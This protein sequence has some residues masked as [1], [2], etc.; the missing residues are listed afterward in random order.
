MRQAEQ[1]NRQRQQVAVEEVF[2]GVSAPMFR[3]QPVGEEAQ[4]GG[5][6][7]RQEEDGKTGPELCGGGARFPITANAHK[8]DVCTLGSRV[9][10][11]GLHDAEE[12]HQHGDDLEGVVAFAGREADGHGGDGAG[13][14]KDDVQGDG[15]VVAERFVVEDIDG[16]EEGGEEGPFVEGDASRFEVEVG[17]A[18]GYVDV[19]WESKESG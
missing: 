16:D 1:E 14:A 12:E 3:V 4:E 10:D 9:G 6:H 8:L 11:G 18:A 17:E 2:F 5:E 19:F 15:D 7:Q 13:A